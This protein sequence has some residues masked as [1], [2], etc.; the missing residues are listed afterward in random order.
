MDSRNKRLSKAAAAA[1]A[2]HVL[3]AAVIGALGIQNRENLPP[4]IIEITLDA[5]GGGGGGNRASESSGGPAIL[6]D[7]SDIVEKAE[8]KE[9]L[10]P[11]KEQEEIPAAEETE[12]QE[13]RGRETSA[14]PS[15]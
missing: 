6:K 5:G 13:E 11:E 1:L 4:R 3:A 15:A 7:I 9:N 2:F 14:M 10:E 8:H 12:V